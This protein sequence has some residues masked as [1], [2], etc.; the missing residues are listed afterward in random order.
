MQDQVGIVVD[1][2]GNPTQSALTF[3]ASPLCIAACGFFV[4]C[5]GPAGV[6][7]LDRVGGDEV[8]WLPYPDGLH[9]SPGQKVTAATSASSN[10]VVLAGFRKVW[11]GGAFVTG[12][13]FDGIRSVADVFHDAT[14]DV[15][16]AQAPWP[17]SMDQ[18]CRC[19]IW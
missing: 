7:V 10:C 19:P 12:T 5:A 6:H 9:P 18:A 8:Q 2:D 4:L 1:G 3:P 16:F 13:T 17:P 15:P 11:L 14:F